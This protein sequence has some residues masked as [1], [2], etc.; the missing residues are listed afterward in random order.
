MILYAPHD[1]H[2]PIPGTITY[3]EHATG[4]ELTSKGTWL[5]ASQQWK[6]AF[7]NAKGT[8]RSTLEVGNTVIQEVTWAG[9]NDGDMLTPDGQVIPATGNSMVTQACWLMTIEDGKITG[10]RH[11]F[12]MLSMMAQ[13]GLAG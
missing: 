3:I 13:L 11:Y 2:P 1:W 10:A 12:D 6:A 9:T 8:I 7:P 4:R 5:E